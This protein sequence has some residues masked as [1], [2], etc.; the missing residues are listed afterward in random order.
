MNI[1]MY[2]HVLKPSSICKVYLEST[3]TEH[4][5]PYG[6]QVTGGRQKENSQRPGY[7]FNG[8]STIREKE[9]ESNTIYVNV[10]TY[11]NLYAYI[12]LFS[13]PLDGDADDVEPDDDDADGRHEKRVT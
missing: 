7:E 4:T 8:I 2:I 9:R 1:Y 3:P 10:D 11:M 13:F 6:H 12:S 5:G